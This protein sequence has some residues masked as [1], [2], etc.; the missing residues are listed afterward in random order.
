[1]ARTAL[2]RVATALVTVLVRATMR[3]LP[4]AR[5]ENIRALVAVI[6]ALKPVKLALPREIPTPL[7]LPQRT[8][9]PRCTPRVTSLL[10]K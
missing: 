7:A 6:P 9:V 5:P 4:P 1:M 2:S 10:A 8:S 3:W